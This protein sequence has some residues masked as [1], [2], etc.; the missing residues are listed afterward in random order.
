[1]EFNNFLSIPIISSD[2]HNPLRCME[3]VLL[4]SFDRGWKL[5]A[6]KLSSFLKITQV[7]S[8]TNPNLSILINIQN[9]SH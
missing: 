5:K 8:K 1:M 6:D 3:Y 9:R 2:P 7:N 4:G